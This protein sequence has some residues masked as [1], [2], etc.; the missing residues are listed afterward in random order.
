MN[1]DLWP[2]PGARWW[3]FDFH[4]HTPAS[5]DYGA[6]L[7]QATLKSRSHREW[8]MGYIQAGV[9]CVAVT[10]HNCGNWIDPLKLELDKMRDEGAPGASEFHVFP[11]AE[12]TI[13]GAHYLAVF[14]P[15]ATTKTIN[16]LLAVAS[17]NNAQ[18]NAEGYCNESVSQICE[19][20]LDRGGLFIPAHV[21]L[22]R[23]GIFKLQGNHSALD[24][25]LKLEGVLAMEVCDP[26]YE[27][28]ACYTDAKLRW[29]RILGSDAHHPTKPSKDESI[30]RPAYPDCHYTPGFKRA[31]SE[32]K[33]K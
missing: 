16:D 3:R 17:Y 15:S 32:R 13:N 4:T 2:Y 20:V 30:S 12:L 18:K 19:E 7:K 21:D 5:S 26:G 33:A 9:S 28:P 29:T 10:D 31:A 22:E 25:I 14:D 6:G 24:P 11:G 8:L 1:K 23:T 27:P